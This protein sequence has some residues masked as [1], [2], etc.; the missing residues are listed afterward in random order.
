MLNRIVVRRLFGGAAIFSGAAFGSGLLPA[1]AQTVS[2]TQDYALGTGA[3]TTVQAGPDAAHVDI[4]RSASD[5]GG[6]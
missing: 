6:N 3:L 2:A 4:L 1:Q 5:A